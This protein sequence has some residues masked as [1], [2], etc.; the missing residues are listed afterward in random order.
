MSEPLDPAR[1]SA[2]SPYHSAR[3]R[4][5]FLGIMTL[6]YALNLFDRKLLSMLQESIKAD[7][8][9]SDTQLGLL[10]GTAFAFFYVIAGVPIA[11]FADRGGNR[12]NIITVAVGLWSFMTALSGLAG[13]YMHLFLA[14][15]GVGL[16]EAG[17]SPPAHSMISDVF[18]PEQRATAMATYS[19]GVNIGIMMGFLLGGILNEYFGWRIA[20]LAVGIPGIFL[21]ILIRTT[22][23]EPVRGWS[24]N[25]VVAPEVIN[26]SEALGLLWKSKTFRHLSVAGG[27]TAL[28]GYGTMNWS[29]PFFIRQFGLG[30]AELGI[31]LALGSGV[32]GA[33]GTYFA[34]FY[35]DRLSRIDTRWNL[36]LPALA[37]VIAGVCMLFILNQSNPYIALSINLLMGGLITC[38]I[39]PSIATL[40]GIVDPRMRATV[41][42]VFYLIIN[43]I[44]LGVGPTLIGVISDH[45]AATLGDGSLR[46]A[47]LIVI[48]VAALWSAAHFMMAARYLRKGL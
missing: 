9:L 18:P 34:G 37:A 7:L 12:R 19:V 31:W 38:Y 30:T 27:L 10:T 21:A 20:F 22:I 32:C 6:T 44:G 41:S 33:V 26:L 39:G 13:S 3:V 2:E 43:V 46:M 15:M 40:H 14:R 35:C 45:Y 16:G 24:E 8:L 42:A 48:P 11:R 4:N 5:Y 28:M 29:A 1:P 25:R 36:W 47:L 17:G 23:V